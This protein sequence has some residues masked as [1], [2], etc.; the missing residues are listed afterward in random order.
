MDTLT[1]EG[2]MGKR[3]LLERWFLGGLDRKKRR[4]EPER[5]SAP[6]HVC[7]VCGAPIFESEAVEVT[8][9]VHVCDEACAEAWH[10][11]SCLPTE[12]GGA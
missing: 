7:V 9:G 5:V 1:L 8:P 2:A 4:R 10:D 6:R 12:G 3:R 11:A